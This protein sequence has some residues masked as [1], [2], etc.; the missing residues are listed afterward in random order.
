MLYYPKIPGSRNAPS[1]RCVAFEKLDGTNLHWAWDRDFGWHA[2]GTRRDEFNLTPDG[3]AQFATAHPGL[4][5]AAEVFLADLAT[6]L[7]RVFR[8]NPLCREFTSHTAF[9]EFVGPNSFAGAHVPADPKEVVLFDVLAGDAWM[10][11]P[12]QFVA[13]FGHLNTPRVVYEGKLTGT[14][15]EAVREGEYGVAEGVVCK[16]GTGGTDVWMVK[17]KTYSY[18][19]RLKTAFGEKWQ[20]YWE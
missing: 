1:G 4:E 20:A 13:D 17:V 16:G 11:G 14:F 5:Q 6:G 10:T 3:I 8:E 12:Y 9:T 2:F 18:L 7:E 15:L 19:G